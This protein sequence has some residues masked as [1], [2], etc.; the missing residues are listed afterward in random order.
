MGGNFSLGPEEKSAGGLQ[1]ETGIFTLSQTAGLLQ[2]ST[3]STGSVAGAH[4]GRGSCLSPSCTGVTQSCGGTGCTGHPDARL[5]LRQPGDALAASGSV[6]VAPGSSFPQ[7]S[8]VTTA[9]Q[10]KH[11]EHRHRQTEF[12][13]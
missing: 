4:S 7:L 5:S 2:G 12:Q 1:A 3:A 13:R 11:L 9:T 10:P 6:C 8:T